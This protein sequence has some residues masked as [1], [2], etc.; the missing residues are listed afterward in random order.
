MSRASGRAAGFSLIEALVAVAILGVALAAIVPGFVDNLRLNT[1]S[2]VRS[3]A[4]R[5]AQQVLEDARSSACFVQR[6]CDPTQAYLPRSGSS[7]PLPV[8]VGG[9]EYR[10]VTRYCAEAAYCS[11]TTRHLRVEVNF[12]GRTVYAA[13]TVYS[14]LN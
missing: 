2:E 1:S 3:G 7:A 6:D 14:Q 12:D 9:R 13:D 11:D 8:W 10:V 5:A 4:V